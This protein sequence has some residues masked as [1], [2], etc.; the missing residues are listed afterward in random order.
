MTNRHGSGLEG[1][2]SARNHERLP[3][4]DGAIHFYEQS[5]GT[6]AWVLRHAAS[7]TSAM[8]AATGR[9]ATERLAPGARWR[10]A[11][12]SS[13]A[14]GHRAE[15]LGPAGPRNGR[16]SGFHA[17]RSGRRRRF[18]R[19]QRGVR[20]ADLYL[21]VHRHERHIGPRRGERSDQQCSGWPV[22]LLPGIRPIGERSLP[23]K[24]PG[25]RPAART[26]PERLRDGE[27]QPLHRE[28]RR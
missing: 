28:C 7:R 20:R 3:L 26:G 15:W 14:Y 1:R 27:Q 16:R 2:E 25:H 12:T 10:L 11:M 6:R 24:R 8:T 18:A 17:V 19:P 22:C 5:P 4:L 13:D 23:G 9:R 21:H